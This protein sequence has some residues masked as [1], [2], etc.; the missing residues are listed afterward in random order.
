MESQVR[1]VEDEDQSKEDLGVRLTVSFCRLF[2]KI[3]EDFFARTSQFWQSD[4]ELA[5][6]D[7]RLVKYFFIIMRRFFAR[8]IP[9]FDNS[10][11]GMLQDLTNEIENQRH[12]LEQSNNQLSEI[13]RRRDALYADKQWVF[14]S[15]SLLC[16]CIN[17]LYLQN[18]YQSAYIWI[19]MNTSIFGSL[20][21]GNIVRYELCKTA[22]AIS[23]CFT[24]TPFRQKCLF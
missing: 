17:Q 23:T 19:H 7:I 1:E 6:F 10:D 15:V 21:Y 4:W 5:G 16:I 14:F 24:F 22:I 9:P 2:S 18:V 8:N 20:F 3:F 13:K 11:S 12:T